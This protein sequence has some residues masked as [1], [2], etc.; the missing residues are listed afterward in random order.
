MIQR[1]IQRLKN[2]CKKHLVLILLLRFRRDFSF[3]LS[4]CINAKLDDYDTA[5]FYGVA[6]SLGNQIK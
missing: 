1:E 6:L 4:I 2:I 5:N 3:L